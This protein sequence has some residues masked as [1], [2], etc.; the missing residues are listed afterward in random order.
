ML[1][2]FHSGSRVPSALATLLQNE[3]CHGQIDS[4]TSSAEDFIEPSTDHIDIF[5]VAQAHV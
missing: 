4:Q 5:V 1:G 3:V 2:V